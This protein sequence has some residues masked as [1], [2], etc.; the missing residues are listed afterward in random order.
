MLLITFKNKYYDSNKSLN[1]RGL[2]IGSCESAWLADLTMSFLLNTI[3]QSLIEPLN[4]FRIYQDNQLAIIPCIKSVSEI[5]N[6]L[7]NFQ[8]SVNK[9]A[10]NNNLQL[11]KP[12]HNDSK[13]GNTSIISAP[14]LPFL[15]MELFWDELED[16]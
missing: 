5:D 10:G 8:N 11:W 4:Y 7:T 15:N 14:S 16:I 1:K 13:L 2:T 6:W 9:Q 12:R 3:N